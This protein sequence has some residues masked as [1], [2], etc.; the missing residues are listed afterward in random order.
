VHLIGP[1]AIHEEFPGDGPYHPEAEGYLSDKD[2][3]TSG[4]TRTG[5]KAERTTSSVEELGARSSRFTA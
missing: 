2:R 4:T 5:R 1:N 3:E